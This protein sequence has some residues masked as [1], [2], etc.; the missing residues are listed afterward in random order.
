MPWP[1]SSRHNS[2]AIPSD[3]A[4]TSRVMLDALRSSNLAIAL[5]LVL[6]AISIMITARSSAL[7]CL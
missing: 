5:M 3:C 1:R 2:A 6:L 4:P 7:R